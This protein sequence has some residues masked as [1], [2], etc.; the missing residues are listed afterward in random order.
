MHLSLRDWLTRLELMGYYILVGRFQPVPNI[1]IPD[2]GDSRLTVLRK[3]HY[4]GLNISCTE[5]PCFGVSLTR[6]QGNGKHGIV[7]SRIRMCFRTAA[8]L[9][10]NQ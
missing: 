4:H 1:H 3:T 2:T 6:T 9:N 8:L 10:L 5:A 7:S